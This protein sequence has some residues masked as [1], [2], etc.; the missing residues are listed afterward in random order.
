LYI[1]S[2]QFTN[3]GLYSV[4]IS[5]ANNSTTNIPY[6]LVIYL[7]EVSLGLRASL[8]IGG[9]VGYSYEIQYS[10]NLADTNSWISI[11]NL[12]LTQPVEVWVDTSADVRDQPRRYYKVLPQ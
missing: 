1:A 9:V 4:V 5:S 6:Q 7:A 10:T 3:G 11:T 8:T 12:T 2:V